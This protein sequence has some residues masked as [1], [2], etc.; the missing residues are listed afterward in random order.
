MSLKTRAARNY[1]AAVMRPSYF[2]FVAF[3]V[4]LADFLADF[5]AGAFFFGATVN[6]PV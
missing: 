1:R 6:P 3:F 2:F 4:F 5:F